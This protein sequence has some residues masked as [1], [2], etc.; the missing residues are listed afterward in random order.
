MAFVLKSGEGKASLPRC[1]LPASN[2]SEGLL[3]FAVTEMVT[4][5]CLF[6]LYH[7]GRKQ[8]D[9]HRSFSLS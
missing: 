3:C 4:L 7:V 8:R 9:E 1:S 6:A 2:A 5:E